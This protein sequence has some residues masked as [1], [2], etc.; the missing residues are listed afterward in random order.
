MPA[1]PQPL[2]REERAAQTRN[3]V[4]D[5][6]IE[7]FSEQGCDGTPLR[8]IA[9]RCGV[10]QPLILYHFENKE[11]LW[12]AAVDEVC[13]RMEST[14][15]AWMLE[16]GLSVDDRGEWAGIESPESLRIV[17]RAFVHAVS[18][19]P[20][21]LH[22][23]LREGSH[24][25]PRFDWLEAHHTRRN[26]ERG[27]ALFKSLQ[28]RGF[29]PDVPAEHLIYILAGAL[30]FIFAVEADVQKQTGQDPRS[31]AFLDAHVEALLSLLR[32]R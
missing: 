31:E 5:A 24:R 23:L 32:P 6:A 21:Y 8:D 7:L 14:L 17:M 12:K 18:Q 9:E 16:H 20:E 25:G 15:F 3:A 27:T 26:F 28:Q 19:H 4:L 11:E 22:M 10:K 30:M 1:A 2:R 29:F 13:G